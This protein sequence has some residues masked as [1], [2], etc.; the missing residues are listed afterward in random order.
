[1]KLLANTLVC[2]LLVI[3]SQGAFSQDIIILKTGDEITAK[4]EEIKPDVVSYRKFEN[5]QGPL[6]TVEKNKIFMIKYAN[7]SKDVF[8]EQSGT[9]TPQQHVQTTPQPAPVQSVPKPTIAELPVTLEY[10]NGGKIRKNN[11]TL[12][13][14]QVKDIMR[15]YRGLFAIYIGAKFKNHRR[16]V[17]SGRLCIF[18]SALV[19]SL[20]KTKMQA[21]L[22]RLCSSFIRNKYSIRAYRK[23]QH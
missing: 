19:N 9:P 5:L 20:N 16:R 18:I 4:V 1:M 23:K 15:P 2:I 22:S 14:T 21:S 12:S 6:Y 8:T 3:C 10:W 7:G 17:R 13:L 11:T